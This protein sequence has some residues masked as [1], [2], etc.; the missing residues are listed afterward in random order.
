MVSILAPLLNLLRVPEPIGIPTSPVARDWVL[1]P[2][3]PTGHI[4]KLPSYSD[5]AKLERRR[6][7]VFKIFVQSLVE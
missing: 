5:P 3:L 7:I 4:T 2:Q 6:S 1:R